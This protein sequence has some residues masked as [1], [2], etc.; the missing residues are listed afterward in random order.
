MTEKEGLKGRIDWMTTLIP[1]A[2]V[3][4]LGIIFTL[5]PE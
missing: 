2:G 3:A 1:F 4:A 5:V